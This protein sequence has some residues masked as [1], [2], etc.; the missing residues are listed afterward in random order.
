[1]VNYSE[2]LEMKYKNNFKIPKKNPF[3]ITPENVALYEGLENCMKYHRI[4]GENVKYLY[5]NINK[6]NEI[7]IYSKLF[8]NYEEFIIQMLM[9]D[10]LL[11]F[12]WNE[13]GKKDV[14]L[15]NYKVHERTLDVY[16][17]GEFKGRMR[18]NIESSE[19]TYSTEN[20]YEKIRKIL[21]GSE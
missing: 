16:I 14:E 7:I 18:L 9:L 8:S 10:R 4:L 21:K 19:E 20:I 2:Y 11:N 17:K 5:T 12:A 1:M 3:E 6:E 15:K 13:R